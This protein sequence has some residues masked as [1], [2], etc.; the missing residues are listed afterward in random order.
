[1][2]DITMCKDYL[3]SIKETCYR[4]TAVPSSYQSY[5]VG[6][7]R[8]KEECEFYWATKTEKHDEDKHSDVKE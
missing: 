6:T 3:C 4:F 5:F 1:M 7:P 2:A 8:S